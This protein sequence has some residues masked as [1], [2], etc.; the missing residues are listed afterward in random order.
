MLEEKQQ[1][2]QED[3]AALSLQ[4]GQRPAE[5]RLQGMDRG[6]GPLCWTPWGLLGGKA[7]W[8]SAAV[9]IQGEEPRPEPPTTPQPAPE[10]NWV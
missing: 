7:E 9:V 6:T 5:A 8:L 10:C 3:K 4:A 1:G 2:T